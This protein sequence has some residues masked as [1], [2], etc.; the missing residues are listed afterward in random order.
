MGPSRSWGYGRTFRSTYY[1]Y[2]GFPRGS[3]VKNPPA[4]A[5]DLGS[6]PGS[7]RLPGEG[8]GNPFQYSCLRNPMDRE[9]WRA[10]VHSVVKELDTT[11]LLN[12]T[13][14]TSALFDSFYSEHLWSFWRKKWQPTPVLLPGESHGRGAWQ[15]TVHGVTRVRYDLVTKPPPFM[16]FRWIFPCWK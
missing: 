12:I 10:T 6:I 7:G 4:N 13:F 2:A 9:A 14:C 5:G 11:E 3:V 8:N 1:F 16:K 15:A